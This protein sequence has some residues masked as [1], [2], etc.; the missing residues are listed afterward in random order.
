MV[1]FESNSKYHEQNQQKNGAYRLCASV[2]TIWSYVM[3][4]SIIRKKKYSSYPIKKKRADLKKKGKSMVSIEISWAWTYSNLT[5][6]ENSWDMPKTRLVKCTS[7]LF[8]E[9]K[10]H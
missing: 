6:E 5:L 2:A 10:C 4:F 8:L 3:C 1:L 9:D 7:H